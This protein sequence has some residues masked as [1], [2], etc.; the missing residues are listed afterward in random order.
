MPDVNAVKLG[1]DVTGL[2]K[3]SGLTQAELAA[4]VGTDRGG[5]LRLENG[6]RVPGYETLDRV[7]AVIGN[8]AIEFGEPRPVSW[9]ERRRRARKVLAGYTFDP[10]ERGPDPAEARS[11]IADGFTPERFAR[12]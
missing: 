3:R 7:A 10:W 2:R 11:L 5:D 6:L 1:I 9:E 8:L 12:P 4:R